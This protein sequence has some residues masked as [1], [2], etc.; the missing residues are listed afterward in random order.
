MFHKYLNW[1]KDTDKEIDSHWLKSTS[2][3]F[4]WILIIVDS[5]QQCDAPS[6]EFLPDT[7]FKIYCTNQVKSKLV[8]FQVSM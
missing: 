1:D 4:S 7:N 2:N 6:V 8:I 5:Y 3:S